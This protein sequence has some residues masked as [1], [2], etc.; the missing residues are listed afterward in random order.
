MIIH[1]K[2]F[3]YRLLTALAI[4]L[5]TGVT[6]ESFAGRTAGDNISV[7]FE[8]V[9]IRLVLKAIEAQSVYQFLYKTSC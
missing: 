5:F 8:K 6:L 1:I 7:N 9:K 3:K 4:L 2:K